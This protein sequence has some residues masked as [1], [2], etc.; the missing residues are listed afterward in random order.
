MTQPEPVVVLSRTAGPVHGYTTV[1]AEVDGGATGEYLVADHIV[2]TPGEVDEI[3]EQ[4]RRRMEAIRA[5]EAGS[6]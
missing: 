5:T 4:S 1:K 3:R 2:A 6:S